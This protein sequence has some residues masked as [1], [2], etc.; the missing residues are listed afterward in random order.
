M[1]TGDRQTG[2]IEVLKTQTLLVYFIILLSSLLTDNVQET[3]RGKPAEC[4][5]MEEML[6]TGQLSR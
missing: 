4:P 3:H 1:V 2:R 5:G 6:M